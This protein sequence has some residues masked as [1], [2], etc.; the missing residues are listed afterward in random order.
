MK[1][2]KLTMI[3]ALIACTMV[4]LA[5]T[6]GGMTA[7]PKKVVNTTFVKAIHTPGLLYAMQTQ[8]NPGFLNNNQLIYTVNVTYDGILY[9]ITGTSA[10]WKAFFC[11]KL[12][13]KSEI[14]PS[15]T[16]SRD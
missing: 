16:I 14:K 9:R 4:A 15:F 11:P 12:K 5:S 7:K 3:A 8:L 10:Q 13:I 1:A 2:L 6:D